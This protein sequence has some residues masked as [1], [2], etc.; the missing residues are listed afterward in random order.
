MELFIIPSPSYFKTDKGFGGGGCWNHTEFPDGSW[1]LFAHTQQKLNT[2]HAYRN[3]LEFNMCKHTQPSMFSFAINEILFTASRQH[4][5][6][7]VSRC[8]LEAFTDGYLQR[9]YTCILF[10]LCALWNIKLRQLRYI[11]FTKDC[12]VSINE[13]CVVLL[14]NKMIKIV[15]VQPCLV[16][17]TVCTDGWDVTNRWS[18]NDV[19]NRRWAVKIRLLKSCFLPD[20]MQTLGFCWRMMVSKWAPS[21]WLFFLIKT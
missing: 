17:Q 5:L 9:L 8:N 6:I 20:E 10:C 19:V 3:T 2:A 13:K 15:I 16:L 21:S 12:R 18:S 4:G 14:S 7:V 11:N 1:D